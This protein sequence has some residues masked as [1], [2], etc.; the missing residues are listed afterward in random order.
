MRNNKIE[1]KELM[2]TL[3]KVIIITIPPIAIISLIALNGTLY[4]FTLDGPAND[5]YVNEDILNDAP[6]RFDTIFDK[7][8]RT[9]KELNRVEEA[10]NDRGGYP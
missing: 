8:D 7:Y 5:P 2:K 6:S 1:S 3:S 10:M 9:I 4:H